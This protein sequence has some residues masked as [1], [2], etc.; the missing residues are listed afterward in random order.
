[1]TAES[2]YIVDR[3][4][5]R[6]RLSIWRALAVIGVVGAALLSVYAAA[7]STFTAEG[8]R[9]D[10]IARL[11]ISGVI[12]DDRRLLE[13]IQTLKEADRVKGVIVSIASPGGTASGGEAIY[14]ALRDLSNEKPTVTFISA[15]AAS[16]GYMVALASDHIVARSNAITGSI[17][18]IFQYANANQLLDRVGVEIS[19]I[20]SSEMKAEPDF[21]SAPSEQTKAMIA[22][23]V[24][25]SYRWFEEI[26]VD[27]R[28]LSADAAA[29]VGNGAIFNGRQAL[30]ARLVDEIGGEADAKEWLVT[31]HALQLSLPIV[32]WQA[33]TPGASA[34]GARLIVKLAASLGLNI[35][36]FFQLTQQHTLDGLLSVW[37]GPSMP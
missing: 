37:H 6:R 3:R 27:R 13:L 2:D 34:F 22:A 21:Y 18:V 31:E 29:R 10:H 15:L 33:V 7:P 5:L 17:G 24:D 28:N 11:S 36:R 19:A 1:M 16:A 23:L 26:V 14:E 20:K 4:H 8:K 25:D 12:T 30:A 9:V 32:D 35:E